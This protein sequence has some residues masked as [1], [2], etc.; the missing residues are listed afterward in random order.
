MHTIN[1]FWRKLDLTPS[2]CLPDNDHRKDSDDDEAID[3]LLEDVKVQFKDQPKSNR[4]NWISKLKDIVYPGRTKIKDPSVITN[5]RGRP[6][7]S[8]KNI[9]QV[10]PS[11]IN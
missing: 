7:G 5:K 8:K 1:D 6:I 2:T 3:Q 11:L 9:P 10:R 4:K